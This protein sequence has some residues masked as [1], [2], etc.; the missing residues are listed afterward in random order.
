MAAKQAVNSSGRPPRAAPGRRPRS[1]PRAQPP[2]VAA[3][4]AALEV[5]VP[6]AVGLEEGEQVAL[7]QPQ[8]NGVQPRAQQGPGV[9][10]TQVGAHRARAGVALRHHALDHPQHRRRVGGA[11]SPRRSPARASASAIAACAHL[12]A[13]PCS[14]CALARPARTWARNSAGVAR[15]RGLGPGAPDVDAGVVVGAADPA[16]AVGVHVDAAGWLSSGRGRRCGP[17]RSRTAA[18]G[19]AGGAAAAARRRRRTGGP[20]RR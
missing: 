18:P 7:A 14:P 1:P 3:A 10:G 8:V 2:L 11:A 9:L 17:P 12:A 15:A 6:E 13:E 19:G 16:A 4:R 20:A 5:G